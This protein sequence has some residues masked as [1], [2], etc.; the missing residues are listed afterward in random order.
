MS[1]CWYGCIVDH[2]YGFHDTR[3]MN[4]FIIPLSWGNGGWCASIIIFLSSVCHIRSRDAPIASLS[5]VYPLLVVST[6]LKKICS[7]SSIS[8]FLSPPPPL[9]C[10]PLGDWNNVWI[11]YQGKNIY[12]GQNTATSVTPS[13][14]TDM[15]VSWWCLYAARKNY[16]TQFL[17]P[18]IPSLSLE[19]L[20]YPILDI[21]LDQTLV[22]LYGTKKT[23]MVT[24]PI[25]SWQGS[26]YTAISRRYT[27]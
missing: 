25:P 13:V 9:S 4:F 1:T 14:N 20:P 3:V 6:V 15:T 11:F 2:G 27:Q 22:P 18:L 7:I 12:T 24:Y 8:S 17:V 19:F 10:N 5:A 21:W 16:G 26:Q 23:G